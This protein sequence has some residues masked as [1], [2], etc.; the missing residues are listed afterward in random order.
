MRLRANVTLYRLSRSGSAADELR[1]GGGP[2]PV[3]GRRSAL[4]DLLGDPGAP[5]PRRDTTERDPRTPDR[6][7]GDVQVRR[8]RHG[9]EGVGRA[10]ADLPVPRPRR[11][12]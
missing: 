1:V 7:V 4:Q 9:G 5:G 11:R 8:D 6:S 3:G 2:E 10:L 12:R